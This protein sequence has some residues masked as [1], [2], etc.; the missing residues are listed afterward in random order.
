MIFS[1]RML[2]SDQSDTGWFANQADLLAAQALR[3]QLRLQI[4]GQFSLRLT[5]SGRN[6]GSTSLHSGESLYPLRT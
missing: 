3:P 6:A 1:R 4:A 5:A 2:N